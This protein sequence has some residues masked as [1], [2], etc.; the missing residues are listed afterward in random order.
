M[1]SD[2]IIQSNLS[3]NTSYLMQKFHLKSNKEMA[4]KVGIS[5]PSLS[6]ILTKGT[7]PSVI[8]FFTNV[9]DRFGY[10]MDDMLYTNLREAEN[11]GL[12]NPMFSEAVRKK[13]V[14]LY[15]VYFFQ[16]NGAFRGRE[17][18]P[19]SMALTTGLVYIHQNPNKRQYYECLALFNLP[20]EESDQIYQD[21]REAYDEGGMYVAQKRMEESGSEERR[22]YR[23][24][25]EI[26]LQQIYF[27]FSF[28]DLDRAYIILHRE[29]GTNAM[30]YGGLGLMLST[31]IGNQPKP[32]MEYIGFSR[33]SL[34]SSKDEIAEALIPGYP[35]LHVYEYLDGLVNTAADLYSNAESGIASLIPEEQKRTILRDQIESVINDTLE[36][37]LYRTRVATLN[38]DDAF[39]H[40]ICQFHPKSPASA[41]D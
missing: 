37:N 33:A 23:G 1:L 17:R 39:Y 24:V 27:Q 14:G 15:E 20:K 35:K 5:E 6:R 38:D 18:G 3:K 36:K 4:A 10:N 40:Y 11:G 28:E 12:D 2:A 9:R 13:Y 34:P 25:M 30:Y 26:T 21:I 29:T 16:T 41:A 22:L 31:T 19:H 32:C 7:I 8:P